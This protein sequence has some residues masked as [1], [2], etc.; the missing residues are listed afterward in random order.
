M[1][2]G[3]I[4]GAALDVLEGEPYV[5]PDHPLIVY[6]ARQPRLLIVPHI[7]GNTKESFERTELF[8]ADRVARAIKELK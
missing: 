5:R 3:Q 8:L 4:G 6:A 2:A 7:G 1:D